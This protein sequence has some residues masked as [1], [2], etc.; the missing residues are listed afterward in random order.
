MQNTK[1]QQATQDITDSLNHQIFQFNHLHYSMS[2]DDLMSNYNPFVNRTKIVRKSVSQALILSSKNQLVD[3]TLGMLNKAY[4]ENNVYQNILFNSFNTTVNDYSITEQTYAQTIVEMCSQ[5]SICR[6]DPGIYS[7][8]ALIVN[9]YPEQFHGR[10]ALLLEE[11]KL[12]C[13]TKL[14]LSIQEQTPERCY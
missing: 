10:H 8:L 5:Q 9:N 13:L 11:A 7:T 6:P 3:F 1:L 4:A 12:V 2:S 14:F